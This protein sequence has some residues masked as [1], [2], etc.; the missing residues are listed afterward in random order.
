[1]VS[2]SLSDENTKA[3]RLRVKS[4]KNDFALYGNQS[5]V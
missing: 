2:T 1:M 5:S 3:I 4:S